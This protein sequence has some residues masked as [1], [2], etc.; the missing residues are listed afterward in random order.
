MSFGYESATACHWQCSQL[1]STA[2]SLLVTYPPR[3]YLT[4]GSSSNSWVSWCVV[5]LCTHY[6]VDDA[7]DAAPSLQCGSHG[8]DDPYRIG[9]AETGISTAR[10]G[11]CMCKYCN[12]AFHDGWGDLLKYD[13][14]YQSAMGPETES[15]H[16][17]HDDWDDLQ[18][19]LGI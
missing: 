7:V 19:E 8:D 17:F 16:G 1:R 14:V 10:V 18:A 12:W 4:M 9:I 13:D 15:N 6:A 2:S 11:T 3:L 5:A